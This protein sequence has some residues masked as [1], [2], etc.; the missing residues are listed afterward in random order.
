M[1]RA[2]MLLVALAAGV[3]AC[4]SAPGQPAA[5]SEVKAPATIRDFG[6]LYATNCAGCHGAGGRGGAA[7]ALNDPVYLAIAGDATIR[8][9]ISNGV[10]GTAMPAFASSAGGVLTD[11]QVDAIVQGIR[12]RWARPDALQGAV[13]PPY[14]A[15]Q[16]GDPDR[17]A[18]V[19]GTYCASCHGVDGRGGARASSIV[20]G[21]YLALVSDQ[22]L[23]TIVIV[24]RPELG[25][26]DWRNNVPGQAMSNEEVTD[27]VAWLAAQR[28]EAPGQ[29]YPA[30]HPIAG[31][32]Q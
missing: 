1:N 14:A 16:P 4:R 7:I 9:V 8:R 12:T 26:P 27:V 13:P 15:Q 3:A 18:S 6:T 31:G 23:R 21:S 32:S 24:G 25:A 2:A 10:P 20:D 11:E 29:P 17:G 30:A 28:T 19:Y 5:G 22:A